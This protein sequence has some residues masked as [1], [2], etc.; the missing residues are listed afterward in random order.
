MPLS[1]RRPSQLVIR[2]SVTGREGT[3]HQSWSMPAAPF[4]TPAWQLPTLAAYLVR[5]HRANAAPSLEQFAALLSER[6]AS[7]IP[8][9]Q[10]AYG[11]DP[12]HDP[13]VSC[14]LDFHAEAAQRNETWPRCSLVVLE[15]ET[16][17][18]APWDRITRH[19]GAHAVITATHRE[20]TA[21]HEHWADIARTRPS[22]QAADVCEMAARLADWT[23]RAHR[24]VKAEQELMRAGQARPAS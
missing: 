5:L 21:E 13:R 6:T 17:R 2:L 18:C 9:T 20:I 8:A 3:R 7:P 14:L 15:Q 12:L 1:V 23:R 24:T 11:Y 10:H 19:R 16:G 4:G 22:Q